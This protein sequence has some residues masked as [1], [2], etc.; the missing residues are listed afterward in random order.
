MKKISRSSALLQLRHAFE[1][2]R[3]SLFLGAGC[4]T[5]NRVPTWDHLVTSIY[6]NGLMR[7]LGRFRMLNM[8]ENV[9]LW[10]FRRKVVPLEVA[11]RGL[12][13]Y[14]DDDDDFLQLIR[15]LLYSQTGIDQGFKPAPPKEVRRLLAR[16]RTL[17]S[18][19]R[20]SRQT[21]RGKRGVRSIISYNYDDLLERQIG[22]D[23]CL[24][25]WKSAPLKP[26]KLPIYHVH[27]FVPF[28][29]KKGSKLNEI[30]LSEDQYH[31]AAQDPYSWSNLVQMQALLDSAVLMIGLSLT[32]WNLRRI[33]DNLRSLPRRSRS[34][35]LLKKPKPWDVR[36]LDVDKII[37][38][39]KR[40]ARSRPDKH[41]AEERLKVLRRPTTPSRIRNIIRAVET[42]D[43]NLQE[44]ILADLGIT[45]IWYKDH[46]DIPGIL[47]SFAPST[48]K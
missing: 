38:A 45:V 46:D 27:G 47:K 29:E 17:R 3:L 43:F 32:D 44:A 18:V 25:M 2:G 15:F 12:L 31:R 22:Y 9:S 1:D 34:F 24:P 48:A 4:S 42:L 7:R 11:S 14:F 8:A 28:A 13:T 26:G 6:M 30:V 16:N 40:D 20:L 37:R 21:I 39:M 23:R 36:D 35:A 5:A 33:L 10:A 41:W 19:A